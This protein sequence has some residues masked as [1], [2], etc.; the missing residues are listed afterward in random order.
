MVST[1]SA[2]SGHRRDQVT[3]NLNL[4]FGVVLHEPLIPESG[5]EEDEGNE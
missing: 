4:H 3:A 2:T 5:E 1:Y